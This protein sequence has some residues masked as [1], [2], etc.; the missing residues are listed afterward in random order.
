[1]IDNRHGDMLRLPNPDADREDDF[2]NFL[3]NSTHLIYGFCHFGIR[4]MRQKYSPVLLFFHTDSYG[5]PPPLE[6]RGF[7]E[8][9]IYHKLEVLYL[10]AHKRLLKFPKPSRYSVGSRIENTLLEIIELAYLGASKKG[11][12]LLLILNKADVLLKI[13]RVHLRLAHKTECLNDAGFAELSEKTIEIGK[14]LGGWIR[15][16]KAPS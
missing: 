5:Y 8:P 6:S 2:Q 12:S 1:M 7:S 16:T 10:A 14:L 3:K 13:L 11:P 9:V 4:A 15:N